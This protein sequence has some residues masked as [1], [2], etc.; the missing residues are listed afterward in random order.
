M[1]VNSDSSVVKFVFELKVCKLNISSY[2][3]VFVYFKLG[4]RIHL[5]GPTE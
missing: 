4:G 5:Q 1:I 3:T 2:A